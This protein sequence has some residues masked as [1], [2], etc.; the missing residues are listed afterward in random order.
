MPASVLAA[1]FSS[2]PSQTNNFGSSSNFQNNALDT[3][4][5]QQQTFGSYVK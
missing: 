1:G 5:F 4:Y 3:S 2:A